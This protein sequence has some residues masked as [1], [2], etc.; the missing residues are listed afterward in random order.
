MTANKLKF[1]DFEA[2]IKETNNQLGTEFIN[3]FRSQRKKLKGK[4]R[5]P[6]SGYLLKFEGNEQT[7]V[8]NEGSKDEIQYHL[9]VREGKIGYGFGINTRRGSFYNDDILNE[10]Q[11][12]AKALHILLPKIQEDFPHYSFVI[13]ESDSLLN[14]QYETYMLFGNEFPAVKEEGSIEVDG[15]DFNQVIEDLKKQLPWYI[16]IFKERNEII[17]ALKQKQKME[18]E[19]QVYKSLLNLKPQL[20]LQGPPGTGKTRL[21][22]ILATSLIPGLETITEVDI[23]NYL[24]EGQVIT[25]TGGQTRYTVTGADRNKKRIEILRESGTSD[26]TSFND[27][28]DAYNTKLWETKI[29]DN[30]PRRSG[31]LAK[32]VYDQLNNTNLSKQF[33]IIQFHPAY[34]YEDFVRGITAKPNENGE[35]ILY[36][37]ENKTL[38]LFA[39]KAL[40]NYTNS[41]KTSDTLSKEIWIEKEFKNFVL[42]IVD[43]LEKEDIELTKKVDLINIDSDAFRYKGKNGWSKNGNRM[44][45]EDIKK[46]YLDD[47]KERQDIVQNKN[48]SSL[49]NWHATYFLEVL[50]IFKNYLKE[51]K[52][53]FEINEEN[54]VS[55]KNYVLIIDEINRANLPSVL[56]ELIY[57]L[58]YRDEEVDSMYEIGGSQ[59]ILLP[60]NLFIIGTMNT[61]DRSVG[62]I[63]YAIRRRF[64]F[65][66]VLPN[67]NVVH[68]LAQNLFKKVSQLFVKNY[69]SIDW[70]KPKPEKSKFLVGDFRP[71]DVW[72]GHSY[73]ISTKVSD[74]EAIEELKLKLEYEIKPL[75]KEYVKDGILTEDAKNEIEKLDEHLN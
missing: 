15:D 74:T 26:T 35:G 67:K 25:S 73:F 3:T 36:E 37:A 33:K 46:A 45:F 18:K 21:A 19:L 75:L 12:Y 57:A 23:I 70:S 4:D 17:S 53:R 48:L 51:N 28:I 6:N 64:T 44:L 41:K 56:G 42:N 65:V 43:R 47:N 13:E 66:D 16:K 68:P 59:K 31:S 7:W 20:I 32:F 1:E 63:D 55:L 22:K 62:H 54:K 71:E 30:G 50:K 49:A 29:T 69:D 58:E 61:A 2:L 14:L 60:P 11:P 9:Y 8:K 10:V 38:G 52:S 24:N 34:T 39:K 27:I 72:I 40:E 5:K